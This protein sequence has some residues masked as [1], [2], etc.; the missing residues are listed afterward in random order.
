MK[1][2]I[3]YIMCLILLISGVSAV[4]QNNSSLSDDNWNGWRG[5]QKEGVSY[6]NSLPVKWSVDKNIKWKTT[7]PGKA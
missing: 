1:L 7:I 4:S 3:R 2:I 5:L 6:S